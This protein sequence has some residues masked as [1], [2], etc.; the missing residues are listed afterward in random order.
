M[1]NC[2][3][4]LCILLSGDASYWFESG[5]L[6]DLT[7]EG[8]RFVGPRAVIRVRSEILPTEAEPY[9]HQNLKI[10]HNEFDAA[11][12]LTAGYADGIV[13]RDN[14]NAQGLPM[15]LTLTNCGAVDADG[16]EI[17]R[18]EEEKRELKIN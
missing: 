16:C 8:C 1:R 11:V 12:P 9:Y 14:R 3:T 17:L 7:V 10:L 4:E 5:P 13:F 18:L 15:T 6:T 2:E